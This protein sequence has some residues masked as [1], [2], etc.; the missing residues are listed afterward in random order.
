MIGSFAVSRSLKCCTSFDLSFFCNS[1]SILD[2]PEILWSVSR[3]FARAIAKRLTTHHSRVKTFTLLHLHRVDDILPVFAP[4][5]GVLGPQLS[6]LSISAKFSD[7]DLPKW[8]L[9]PSRLEK[10]EYQIWDFLK[11]FKPMAQLLTSATFLRLRHVTILSG[12]MSFSCVLDA[13]ATDNVPALEHLALRND[14]SF[15]DYSYT[16]LGPDDSLRDIVGNIRAIGLARA[17]TLKRIVLPMLDRSLLTSYLHSVID[18][19][20]YLPTFNLDQFK[21]DFQQLF[22]ISLSQ[23]R[24]GGGV[25]S[26]WAGLLMELALRC[27]DGAPDIDPQKLEPLFE[28]C[29]SE[30]KLPCAT[31]CVAELLIVV[32]HLSQITGT[33]SSEWLHWLNYKFRF[34]LLPRWAEARADLLKDLLFHSDVLRPIVDIYCNS[35]ERSTSSYLLLP[36]FEEFMAEWMLLDSD[37]ASKFR[38]LANPKNVYYNR[39]LNRVE[40]LLQSPS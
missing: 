19:D 23:A 11:N 9:D 40:S 30:C 31:E 12:G 39:L 22:G 27:P 13:L 37:V 7:F 18:I 10:I 26:V 28:Y 6:S 4:L 33:I 15:R 8:N 17:G 35:M 29:F 25:Y 24:F 36:D 2:P 38:L 16:V 3:N 32:T 34:S 14:E 20:Q 21:V 1:I 5:V